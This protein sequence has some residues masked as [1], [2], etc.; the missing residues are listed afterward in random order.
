MEFI[1]LRAQYET[2]KDDI[3]IRIQNVLNHGAYINGPEVTS[4][5]SRL[6]EFVG[7]KHTITCANGTD[8]LEIVLRAL[9]VGANDVV[10]CPTF[11]FF[12]TAE[13]ISNLG[14]IPIFVDSDLDTFNICPD[15]LEEKILKVKKT[16]QLNPKAVIAVDLFG[17]PANYDRLEKIAEQQDLFLVEDAAQGFGGSIRGKRAGSFG[18]AATTS[19]FPAKPLGCYGDGGAIFTNSDSINE[20][21]RSLRS[22][23]QG[24]HKYENVRIGYNSRLDTIQAAVLHAKLNVFESE[25]IARNRAAVNYNGLYSDYFVVPTV[26]VGCQSSWAQ[27][28]IKCHDRTHAIDAF[29]KKGIPTNIYY[30]KC[31]HEQDAFRYVKELQMNLPRATSLS[32][33]VL[34]LPMHGYLR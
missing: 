14:G 21:A 23:G 25:L 15:D 9:G 11:T 2:I 18:I 32:Q 24:S 20:L 1:D 12:A 5:E 34:S 33:S 8:A 7:V 17:L 16:T 31:L 28:T 4:L 10:F 27:Y 3:N 30:P 6:S 26:P 29:K 19:F 13:V 22:H